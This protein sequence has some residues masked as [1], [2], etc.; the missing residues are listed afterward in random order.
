MG[1][2]NEG[3]GIERAAERRPPGCHAKECHTKRQPAV[4]LAATI[5]AALGPQ[6]R[7]M[8]RQDVVAEFA[9]VREPRGPLL[10]ECAQAPLAMAAQVGRLHA[11]SFG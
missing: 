6:E 10:V 7:A 8:A 5:A 1:M 9:P 2:R 11:M 3:M 4:Q